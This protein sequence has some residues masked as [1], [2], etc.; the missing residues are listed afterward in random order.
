MVSKLLPKIM[1]AEPA[2]AFT[3]LEIRIIE[4][5]AASPKPLGAYAIARAITEAT[6]RRCHPNSIYRCLAHLI[7]AGAVHRVICKNSYT[8]TS[9]VCATDTLLVCGS[10]DA[11]KAIATPDSH[12]KLER[13]AAASNFAASSTIIEVVGTCRDCS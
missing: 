8:L 10:C 1:R 13:S 6:G 7:E 3:A 5:L 4:R 9:N 12:H 2:A 11:V